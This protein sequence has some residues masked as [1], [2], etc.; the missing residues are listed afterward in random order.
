MADILFF[1][2]FFAIPFLA[3]S[4]LPVFFGRVFCALAV[5]AFLWIAF[6]AQG[7]SLPADSAERVQSLV[8][9]CVALA[10]ILAEGVHAVRGAIKRRRLNHG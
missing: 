10:A 3:F 6:M 9:Q 5:A 8:A 2:P 1:A 7:H 4:V